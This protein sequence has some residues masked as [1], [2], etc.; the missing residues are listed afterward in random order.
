M[1]YVS[2]RESVMR[3]VHSRSLYV[4]KAI[5]ALETRP[6]Q[7]P[8]E[9]LFLPS[10]CAKYLVLGRGKHRGILR[11]ARLERFYVPILPHFPG[12]L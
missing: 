4:C 1:Y 2:S 12:R 7:M 9:L 6:Q 10:A 11:T 8:D 3:R 5:A